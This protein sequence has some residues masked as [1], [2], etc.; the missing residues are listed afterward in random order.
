MSNG[1]KRAPEGEEKKEGKRRGR[2]GKTSPRYGVD[3]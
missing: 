1:G 2:E 3:W